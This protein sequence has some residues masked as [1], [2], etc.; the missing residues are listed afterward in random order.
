MTDETGGQ[1]GDQPPTSKEAQTGGSS[2]SF[3]KIHVFGQQVLNYIQQFILSFGSDSLKI[4][5]E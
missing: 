3:K 2:I 1:E 5:Q 4:F